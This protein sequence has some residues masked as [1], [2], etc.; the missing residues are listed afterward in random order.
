MPQ[1]SLNLVF[2]AL[3]TPHYAGFGAYDMSKTVCPLEEVGGFE[4]VDQYLDFA[5][6][7]LGIVFEE[8]DEANGATYGQSGRRIYKYTDA[9][10]DIC[11]ECIWAEEVG[12]DHPAI[13]ARIADM[14]VCK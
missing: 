13:K 1:I 4:A 10:G 7:E 9:R 3:V 12:D 8:D 2:I 11:R 6:S 14:E 5:N